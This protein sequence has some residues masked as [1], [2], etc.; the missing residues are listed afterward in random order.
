MVLYIELKHA[1]RTL[2]EKEGLQP[3]ARLPTEQ[4]LM[5]RFRVSRM[6]VTRALHDLAAEGLVD[7]RQ[8]VGTFVA[9]PKVLVDLQR[10][11]GFTEDM[12]LRGLRP[13][14]RILQMARVPAPAEVARSLRLSKGAL[15]HL[16]VRLRTA[17]GDPV[18]LHETYLPGELDLEESELTRAGSL[19]AVLRDRYQTVPTE[20]DETIEAVTANA[21]QARL[22][23]V[24][25]GAALLRVERQT[26]DQRGRVFEVSHMLYRGD[27]YQYHTKLQ[28]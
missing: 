22:L 23:S 13:G 1:L 16:I 2:I 12:L 26:Y 20:A 9:R 18:G 21:S 24:R 14:G 4:D 25:P 27:R 11:K 17:N 28:A 5:K 3:G 10:L 6:T 15:V 8:G 19:Y 7:R